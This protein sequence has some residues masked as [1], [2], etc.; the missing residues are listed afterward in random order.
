MSEQTIQP[1][2][3][4]GAAEAGLTQQAHREKIN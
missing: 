4:L 2:E 1:V 3:R